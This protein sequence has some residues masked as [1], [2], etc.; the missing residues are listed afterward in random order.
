MFYRVGLP[1]WKQAAKLGFGL[2]LRVHCHFDKDVNSYWAN[3]PDLN[4][5]VVAADTLEELHKE[6][7]YAALD[8]IDLAINDDHSKVTPSLK[9]LDGSMYA[10]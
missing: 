10:A 8:L 5:L 4:G 6:V 9:F 1:F 7:S 3:S 2:S